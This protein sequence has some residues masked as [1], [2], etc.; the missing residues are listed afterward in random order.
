M[1]ERSKEYKKMGEELIRKVPELRWI[2]EGNIKIAWLTSTQ[3]KTRGGGIVYAD[4]RKLDEWM[5]VFAKYDFVITVYEDNCLG[6]TENQMYI[7]L[8]HE[9]LHIGLDGGSLNPIYKIN[10]HTIEDFK[11]IINRF[12]IDWGEV[13]EAVPDVWDVIENE[14]N[15]EKELIQRE[16]D[17]R[18]YSEGIW[19]KRRTQIGRIKTQC[20]DDA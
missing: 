20:E 15:A 4:C 2:K 7:V 6:L 8:W 16:K 13:G 5:Q 10:P 9:L 3:K 12:G 18:E 14:R 19:E 1:V 11:S 17:R